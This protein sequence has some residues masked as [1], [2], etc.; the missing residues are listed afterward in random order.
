MWHNLHTAAFS[1]SIR[2][3]VTRHLAQTAHCATFSASILIGVLH[4]MWHS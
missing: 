2:K 1:A 3:D 4:A